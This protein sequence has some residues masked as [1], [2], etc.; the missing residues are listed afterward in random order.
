MGL[1]PF[2]F[3]Q[4][5]ITQAHSTHKVG[6][7][8]VLLGAWV[9]LRTEDK[10]ILDIGTGSGVIALMLA[11][12][13]GAEAHIDALDIELHDVEQARE[14]VQRSPWPAKVTVYHEALQA[15]QSPEPYDLIVSNPPYFANSLLPPD[16]RRSLARHTQRLSFDDL[17]HHAA[18]LLTRRGRL[19]LILPYAEG[20]QLTAL[21]Q[22]YG[23]RPQRLTAFHSRAEK[24]AERLLLELGW[25]NSSVK[26]NVLILHGHGNEWSEEYK[27]LTRDFYLKT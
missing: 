17:M 18:R 21:A 19:A 11:Q 6:T 24:P 13:S 22:G 3:K 10:R 26:E 23:L 20:K 2:H 4:F 16:T 15:F 27:A 5:S 25:E 12:R 9:S 14:N 7:D 8:G 1:K